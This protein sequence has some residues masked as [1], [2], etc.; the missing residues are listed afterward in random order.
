MNPKAD[1]Y[2]T[3]LPKKCSKVCCQS[4]VPSIE[5][6][7][8]TPFACVTGGLWC[9]RTCSFS[10]RFTRYTIN[11]LPPR[12]CNTKSMGWGAPKVFHKETIVA[13]GQYEVDSGRLYC[14]T[15]CP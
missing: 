9:H 4:L 12:V 11:S 15:L 1:S 14:R 2:P 10:F 5:I 13:H 3:C 7:T 8:N 6:P